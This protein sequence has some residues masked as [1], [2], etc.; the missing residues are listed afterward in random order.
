MLIAFQPIPG[1]TRPRVGVIG[2][3]FSHPL[4]GDDGGRVAP[5]RL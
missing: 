2:E 1:A 4:A 3:L 5:S